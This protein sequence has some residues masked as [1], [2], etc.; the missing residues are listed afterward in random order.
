MEMIC[1]QK[2][3][4]SLLSMVLKLLMISLKI[5]IYQ[6]MILEFFGL[7]TFFSVFRENF[8][9]SGMINLLTT[10]SKLFTNKSSLKLIK[11]L[12][13]QENTIWIILGRPVFKKIF[14]TLVL[15]CS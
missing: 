6:N 7:G 13:H 2:T 3:A 15:F 12:Q 4:N 10:L 5:S 8:S 11:A 9:W 1:H 14:G